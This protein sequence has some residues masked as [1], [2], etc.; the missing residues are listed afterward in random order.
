M[1]ARNAEP[2]RRGEHTEVGFTIREFVDWSRQRGFEQAQIADAIWPA[3][4]SELLGVEIKNEVNVEPSRLVHF[5]SA[6]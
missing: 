2:V 4:E 5:A 6:L 1:I 3:E